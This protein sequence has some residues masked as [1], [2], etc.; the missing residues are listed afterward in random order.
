MYDLPQM[1]GGQEFLVH[2]PGNEID[3]CAGE[4]EFQADLPCDED[5]Y[6]LACICL[7]ENGW[8]QADNPHAAMALYC[9]LRPVMLSL[10]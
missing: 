8:T 4:C 6:E 10:F 7:E 5:F 3:V 2:V 1:F 9:N